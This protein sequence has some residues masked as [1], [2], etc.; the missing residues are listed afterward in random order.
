MFEIKCA[1]CGKTDLAPFK[2]T[3]GKPAYCKTCFSQ[4]MFKKTESVDLSSSFDS[5]QAW[6]GEEITGKEKR[7]IGTIACQ[8][9]LSACTAKK[10]LRKDGLR[11]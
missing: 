7:K 2:P 11:L 5:K 8:F 4:R 10:P 6:R 1:E 9:G 3:A